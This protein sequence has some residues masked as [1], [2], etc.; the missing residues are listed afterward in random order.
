MTPDD[1]RILRRD[2]DSCVV[3]LWHVLHK[4]GPD[5]MTRGDIELWYQITQHPSI[6]RK[7]ET[8]KQD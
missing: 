6:R 1:L 5:Y 8:G 7:L 3:Q 4:L 2:V